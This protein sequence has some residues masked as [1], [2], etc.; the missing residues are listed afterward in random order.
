ME[1]KTQ[2]EKKSKS[3]LLESGSYEIFTPDS[4]EFKMDTLI[5]HG[6]NGAKRIWKLKS[7]DAKQA[8]F[9]VKKFG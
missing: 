9:E 2:S 3:E 4:G 5:L 1:E 8:I 6:H 7:L